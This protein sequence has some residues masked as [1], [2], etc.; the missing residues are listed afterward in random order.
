MFHSSVEAIPLHLPQLRTNP[1]YAFSIDGMLGVQIFFV[2]SGFCIAN[3][4][5][6]SCQK[7]DGVLPFAFARIRRIYPPYFFALLATVGMSVFAKLLVSHHV[8]RTSSMAQ[9]NLFHQT[10]IW[11]I[12]QLTLSQVLLGQKPLI[13]IFWTLCYEVAF[14]FVVGIVIWG[15]QN[16]RLNGS[17]MLNVLHLITIIFM[18]LLSLAPAYTIF[19]FNMWPQF[20]LGVLA[21]DWISR[22]H[23]RPFIVSSI[24]LGEILLFLYRFD[25][26][27]DS[28]HVGSRGTFTAATLMAALLVILHPADDRVSR[29]PFIKLLAWIGTFSYSLYLIHALP[30]GIVLQLGKPF[31]NSPTSFSMIFLLEIGAALVVAYPFFLIFEKPLLSRRAVIRVNIEQLILLAT[32]S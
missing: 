17:V 30:L 26:G 27:G 25:Y 11:Y 1:V 31:L 8:L 15:I 4:A 2:V 16:F 28:Y 19:P 21:F 23:K 14:Y 3:A 32:L 9:T 20:G 29:L 24:L 5:I 6:S 10:L 13:I 7:K 18:G 22:P 12:S